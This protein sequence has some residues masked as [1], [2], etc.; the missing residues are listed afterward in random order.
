MNTVSGMVLVSGDTKFSKVL[1]FL[2]RWKRDKE[3]EIVIQQCGAFRPVLREYS[4]TGEL[5]VWL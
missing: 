3:E 1:L 2:M 4:S 5:S